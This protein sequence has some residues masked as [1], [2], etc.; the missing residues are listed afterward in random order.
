MKRLAYIITKQHTGEFMEDSFLLPLSLGE[1]VAEVVVIYFVEDGVYHLVKGARSSKN[2]KIALDNSKLTI[3]ACKT[4][5][6]NRNLQNVII[7]GVEQGN[8]N[9]FFKYA[10]DADHIIS[11]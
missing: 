1:H 10:A 6:K 11:F 9:D 3:I 8:F 5:I 2:I 7:E 4:S